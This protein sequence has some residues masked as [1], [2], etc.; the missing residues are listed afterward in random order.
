[1]NSQ[2]FVINGIPLPSG[3]ITVPLGIIIPL[4]G[5][6]SLDKKVLEEL[7]NYN[8]FLVDKMNGNFTVDIKGTS[9]YS[10][11]SDAGTFT[12]RFI[13]KFESI[14]THVG[15]SSFVNKKFNIYG[16]KDYINI[17]PN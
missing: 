2:Q 15:N 12:D 10:F 8:V 11:S 14:L 6:Y 5:V 7:D 9:S 3:T 17:L 13:L 16:T 1:M 4:S